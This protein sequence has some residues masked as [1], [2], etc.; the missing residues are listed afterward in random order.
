MT[1]YPAS[2]DTF[3]NPTAATTMDAAGLEHDVQHANL[4]DAVAALQAKVGVTGSA[5]PASLDFRMSVIE[6]AGTVGLLTFG[7]VNIAAAAAGGAVSGLNLGYV[8]SAVIPILQVPAGGLG[9][10][11]AVVG[12]PTADGFIYAL[13]GLTDSGNYKISYLIAPAGYAASGSVAVTEGQQTGTVAGLNLG[14]TPRSVQVGV[15]LPNPDAGALAAVVVGAP[16]ADGFSWALVPGAA[17]AAGVRLYWI[18]FR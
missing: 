16:T 6:Q 8:P 17:D 11:A 14:F 15:L 18:A 9:L 10:F 5:D 13:S 7:T 2:L 4:N 12:T 1:N 3:Q